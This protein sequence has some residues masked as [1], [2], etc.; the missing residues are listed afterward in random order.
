MKL[1]F[2]LSQFQR[3]LLLTVASLIGSFHDLAYDF[4]VDCIHYK[5]LSA[6]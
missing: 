4:E 1:V 3:M 2:N 5:Y 6:N